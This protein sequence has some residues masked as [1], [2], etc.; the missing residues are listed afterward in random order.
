MCGLNCGMAEQLPEAEPVAI[1]VPFT[2][3]MSARLLPRSARLGGLSLDVT[4]SSRHG[5]SLSTAGI[6][7]GKPPV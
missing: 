1:A 6:S 7:A 2:C 4:A 5:P 3:M